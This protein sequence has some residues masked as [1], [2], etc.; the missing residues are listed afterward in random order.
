MNERTNLDGHP[1][2]RFDVTVVGDNCIDLLMYG[3]AEDLPCERELLADERGPEQPRQ[4]D[5]YAR[6]DG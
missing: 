4:D 5:G 1:S 2:R 3:L 6:L